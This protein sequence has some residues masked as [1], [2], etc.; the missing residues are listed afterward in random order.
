MQSC[1]DIN[2][3]SVDTVDIT[4]K[5][6]LICMVPF[7]SGIICGTLSGRTLC[8][9]SIG[10]ARRSIC[11][12]HAYNSLIPRQRSDGHCPLAVAIVQMHF[13]PTWIIALTSSVHVHVTWT[14]QS[15]S[16]HLVSEDRLCPRSPFAMSFQQCLYHVLP[17][18]RG[19][20][21]LV[22]QQLLGSERIWLEG[23]RGTYGSMLPSGCRVDVRVVVIVCLRAHCMPTGFCMR[24]S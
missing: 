11:R 21:G 15:F 2:I 17:F 13:A 10:T 5:T 1:A 6:T 9:L 4:R 20:V 8:R 7:R 23:G 3:G 14:H 12:L 19:R 18:H 24:K 22:S 16:W